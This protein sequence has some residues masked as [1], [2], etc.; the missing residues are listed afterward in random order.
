MKTKLNLT[1]LAL[2]FAFAITSFAQ[3]NVGVK[4][5]MNIAFNSRVTPSAK[6]IYTLNLNVNESVVFSG[7]ITNTPFI[8]GLVS[9][10]QP[11]RIDYGIDCALI[12]PRNPADVRTIGRFFGTVPITPEG[13]YDYASG[14]LKIIVNQM[15]R[16]EGFESKFL[17]TAQ[18]KPL[19]KSGG[20]LAKAKSA[21]SVAKVVGGKTVTIAVKNYD[22][23]V[24]GP[25]FTMSA[26]PVGVYPKT[27]VT[28]SMIYD[29]DRAA[30]YP[31]D[32]G[33]NSDNPGSK[34]NDKLSGSIRW[35]EKPKTGNTRQG[36]YEF[37]L[38][39]NEPVA[40]EDAAFSAPSDEASFFTV[41]DTLMS[42]AGTMKYTDTFSGESVVRSEVAVA[43]VGNKITKQQCME[44]TKLII[45]SMV[46]PMNNE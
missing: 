34:S 31:K 2:C 24:F 11:A 4:G 39:L 19:K 12:N 15:G 7:V 3:T 38:R 37:D 41:D 45:F 9:V 14:S 35:A 21:L 13:L 1:T 25:T 36:Q 33:V 23:M 30:W 18:G 32:V 26:G 5:T 42:L 17:G 8:D 16:A 29:Y 40:K 28:G 20:L 22:T 43:L 44:L 46:V 10:S 6:D 27:Q